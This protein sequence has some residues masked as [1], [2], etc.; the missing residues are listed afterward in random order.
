MQEFVIEAKV[1]QLEL[2]HREK[3][4]PELPHLFI[5]GAICF[6]PIS[7]KYLLFQ[8]FVVAIMILIV[9]IIR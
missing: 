6:K 5:T 7:L 3:D 9:R 8:H 4:S 1:R 2:L